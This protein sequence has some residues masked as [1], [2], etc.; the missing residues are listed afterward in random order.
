M[1][2][3]YLEKKHIRILSIDGGGIRGIVP[4][5]VL[6]EIERRTGRPTSA[7]F[8]LIAGTSTGGI[9]ALALSQP[10]A[11]G[12]GP[13]HS[14]AKIAA[15]YEQ[16]GPAIFNKDW[17]QVLR[18]A[19]GLVH[20]K[21]SDKPIESALESFFGNVKLSE[22]I[23]SVFVPSY[24][25]TQRTPFFFRSTKAKQNPAYDF[26]MHTVARSTSAAP[27][28]FPPEA[29]SILGSTNKYLMV[30]GGVFANN[31][32]ACALVEARVQ[33]PQAAE[34]TLVSLGTGTLKEAPLMGPP[35]N[36]GLAQWARPIL[37]TVLNGVSSTVDYQMSQLLGTRADG[38]RGYF[39]IQAELT[40]SHQALDSASPATIK[41]L[42]A[43]AAATLEKQSRD[44]DELCEQ[45]AA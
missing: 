32:A 16:L 6:A 39:R 38:S 19:N 34:F 22:A 44:I 8:D 15:F 12:E 11:R 35:E 24:E 36:W 14:A 41:G 9:L 4:A 29:I 3:G 21:Y 42:R 17:M 30:D 1:T 13:A 5:A 25:L 31:P 33:F 23:T 45:I 18:S 27:T 2:P 28:Y 43:I 7:L 26:A 40:S 37:D 20:S 10:D